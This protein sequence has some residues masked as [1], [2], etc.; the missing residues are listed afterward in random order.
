[1]R[2]TKRNKLLAFLLVVVMMMTM[3]PTVVLAEN[4]GIDT[5]IEKTVSTDKELEDALTGEDTNVVITVSNDIELSAGIIISGNRE[6]VL[7]GATSD[8]KITFAE[9][10]DVLDATTDHSMFY[11]DNGANVSMTIQNITLDGAS[12]ARLFY[13]GDT[14]D[15]TK[16]K[17]T[18]ETGSVLQNG[19]PQLAAGETGSNPSGGAVRIKAG[20]EMVMNDGKIINNQSKRYGGG[21][22]AWSGG[23]VVKINGGEISGN[24]GNYAGGVVLLGA[25]QFFLHGG[26]ITNNIGNSNAYGG[27]I[28]FQDGIMHLGGSAVV[29][30]NEFANG[31][32]SDTYFNQNNIQLYIDSA[33]TGDIAF[34]N[35]ERML[36]LLASDDYTLTESDAAH[37]RKT[38]GNQ[39][40]YLD[41]ESNTIKN[42]K[43]C[44]ITFNA[45]DGTDSNYTQKVPMGIAAKLTP[46]T[47]TREGYIFN[48]W[49]TQAD[50][51]GT[52]YANQAEINTNVNMD[53]YAKWISVAEIPSLITMEY[54][55]SQALPS[56]EGVTFDWRSDDESIVTISD[57]QIIAAGAGKTTVTAKATT[58]GGGT[59]TFTVSV[60][61]TPI[62]I[63][64]GKPDETN[65]DGR[66]YIVYSLN[67]DGT[68]PTFNELIGF[69]PVKNAGT[70]GT[71][72]PDT[73]KG[74]ILLQ[75]GTG[76]DGDVEYIYINDASGNL[77]TTDTLPTHP[78]TDAEGNLHSIRVELKLKTPNYRFCT[79]GT[80]WQP[81][82]T[83]VLYV[84]CYEEG[85]TKVDMYLEGDDTPVDTFDDRHAY[86]YTGE[87]IVPTERDLTTLYTKS[88]STSNTITE[89]TAH[90]HA[91]ADKTD[92]AGSHLTQV[93]NSA[94]T[95]EALKAIAPTELGTY[96]FV[97][98]GYNE[99]EK[100]YC[101]ASRRYSIVKGTPT[102][103]PT[104][105]A[106]SSG[107]ALSE[108]TL[109][110]SMKNAAGIEVAGDFT[111]EDDSQIVTCEAS[112]NWTFTPDDLVHYNEVT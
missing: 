66:P 57:D 39:V 84:T 93:P 53:L 41:A 9:S 89:F 85:M 33:L 30:D 94:L 38:T 16:N 32:K 91:I 3:F 80:N 75:P 90:F 14:V 108:V 28:F 72:E 68:A 4:D 37:L 27:G 61:V 101:Y 104:F 19:F 76:A 81:E 112:Y 11:F 102:G 49:N 92:F 99:D 59:G 24:A 7:Q 42:E 8:V 96:S 15:G 100:T 6:I 97:I 55:S 110:G 79:V 65:S 54:G 107:T 87:G 40:F 43:A 5:A 29:R 62:N 36:P 60:E 67:P 111:W 47:F 103:S 21:I 25:T 22:F 48:G 44:D 78:T 1:M 105:N 12:K 50:G 71:Y 69:Y 18:M 64:Y 58:A 77:I 52:D 10:I 31:V 74:Q 34:I 73:D 70:E 51:N 86:E 95:A 46:Y 26:Q 35:P 2:R 63:I 106:V 98:N 23:V 20:S 56:V 109:T 82:D 83:I 88:E 17:L 13:L 45:N